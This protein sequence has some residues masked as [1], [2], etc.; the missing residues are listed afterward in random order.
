MIAMLIPANSICLICPIRS[1]AGMH[2]KGD[3]VNGTFKKMVRGEEAYD[4]AVAG[5]EHDVPSRTNSIP[6]N[7]ATSEPY[8]NFWPRL[9][10]INM[11]VLASK[12]CRT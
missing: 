11:G 4:Q 2:K 1:I 6:V 3:I 10:I 7:R 9:I 5:R 8:D 12:N